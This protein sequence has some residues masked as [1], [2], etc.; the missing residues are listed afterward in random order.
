MKL[1]H[2]HGPQQI[3]TVAVV[4]YPGAGKGTALEGLLHEFVRHHRSTDMFEAGK[5]VS[6]AIDAQTEFGRTVQAYNERG[7]LVPDSII[8][9]KVREGITQLDP[10]AFW[11]IDGFPRNQEQIAAYVLEMTTRQRSDIVLHL[12]LSKD[13]Q[14]AREIADERMRKRGERALAAGRKPRNSDVNVKARNKRLDEAQQL[15]PVIEHFERLGKILTV[16]AMQGIYDV[17]KE[18]WSKIEALLPNGVGH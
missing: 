1:A 6:D 4:A 2:P 8:I 15:D 18:A 11:F 17:R 9:P 14:I 10:E 7:E 16:D 5:M 13:P 3:D 12:Q